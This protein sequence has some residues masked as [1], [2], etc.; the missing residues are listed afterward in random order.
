MAVKGLGEV[1]QV[2]ER[3][4]RGSVSRVVVMVE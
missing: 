3:R 2:K 1:R 4:D